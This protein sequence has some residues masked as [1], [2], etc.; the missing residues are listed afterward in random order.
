MNN[1]LIGSNRQTT[2][3][4]SIFF[5]M[6]VYHDFFFSWKT[7]KKFCLWLI[8][9]LFSFP[10]AQNDKN[11]KKILEKTKFIAWSF[12]PMSSLENVIYKI[13]PLLNNKFHGLSVGHHSLLLDQGF[14]NNAWLQRNLADRNAIWGYFVSMRLYLAMLFI[15]SI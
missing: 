15:L 5:L 14:A 8:R 2:N 3:S 10:I 7:E 6:N 9:S 4:E 12:D 1:E 11:L 13:I